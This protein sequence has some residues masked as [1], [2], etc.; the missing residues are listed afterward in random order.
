[1]NLFK[2]LVMSLMAGGIFFLVACKDDENPI[3]DFNVG[4]KIEPEEPVAGQE[5]TFTNS[6]TGGSTF[7]W[8]FGDGATSEEKNPKHVF[9]EAGDYTVMLQVD[10][11]EELTFEKVVT[12]SEP[13]PEVTYEPSPIEVGVDVTFTA[14]IY[15][16]DEE[17]V[18]YNWDFPAEASGEGVDDEGKITGEAVTVRF[19]TP[20]SAAEV[21]ITAVI[22]SN[23]SST[24]VTVEVKD[25]LAKTLYFAEKGGNI[26]TKQ[27]YASGEA[28]L[29]DFGVSAGAHA[30]TLK[31]NNDKLFVFD[32]GQY[33]TFTAEAE[34]SVG[35]IF[36]IGHDGSDYVTHVTF[37]TNAYDD[38]FFGDVVGDN[39]YFTDRRND[40]TKIPV[41]T[42]NAEWGEAGGDAN[43]ESFPAMVANSQLGYYSAWRTD[44]GPTYGWGAV[45]GKFTVR[46]GVYWWAKNSNHRGIWR[47]SDD[48]IGVTDQVPAAGE[49]LTDYGVRTFAI[50]E[51]NQK[52]YFCSNAGTATGFFVADLD[53]SNVTLIDD[54]PADSEGG[55]TE[56]TYITGIAIDNESGHV[57][58]GY[59]GPASTEENPIDYESNPLYRSGVKMYKLDGSGEV[60]YFVE[61]MEVYGLTIDPSKR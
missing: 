39:I 48:D 13:A 1:M 25:Q 34:T 40:V 24:T 26:W 2:Q 60:E 41:S 33:I 45:N 61:D 49:I 20:A 27:I 7:T 28:E 5:V 21:I 57:F 22:G 58:W 12:V 11:F 38:A 44:G 47:F 10:G 42:T 51:V 52:L 35:Q 8:E 31:F 9:V 3:P 14:T 17:E 55:G 29:T 37:G 19:A 59:R 6:S 16:P 36:S 56:A 18:V 54:A 23:Q 30:L 53:G 32:A 4:F 15:N 50:D 46:D 43:P